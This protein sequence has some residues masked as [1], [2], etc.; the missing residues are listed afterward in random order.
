MKYK[1][2]N[3]S[4]ILSSFLMF[5]TLTCV[6][7]V[8][9]DIAD[10]NS[11][12]VVDG[13]ITNQPGPYEV[14][15]SLSSPLRNTTFETIED[16]AV[17]IEEENGP[18][19]SLKYNNTG[20]YWTDSV[21]LQGQVGNR[22]RLHITLATGQQYQSEWELLK[23]APPIDELYFRFEEQPSPRGGNEKGTR[24]Y[25]STEDPAGDT[26]FYRWEWDATWLHIAPFSSA[27]DFVGND[28]TEFREPQQVC[29]NSTESA[30]ILLESSLNN[31][32]DEIA[33]FPIHFVSTYGIE[34][35]FRY[36]ILVTQYALTEKE[37]L[38]WNSLE[39]ANENS[40]SFYDTQPQ[41][42][43]GN[44]IRLDDPSEPVL[45]Y[46]SASG[47]SQ[48]RLFINRDELPKDQVVGIAYLNDCITR[49]D[50]I[51]KERETE[52]DVFNAI[53]A[54]RRFYD[55]YRDLELGILGWILVPPECH[56][57]T[58]LGGTQ[59]KPEFWDE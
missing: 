1:A 38:F 45:G 41:S 28:R 2:T 13:L 58:E 37:F 56:D 26:K 18:L 52:Q 53:R 21:A 10:V 23:P 14:R 29:Y 12:L 43:T 30:T 8:D 20:R 16:A 51:L 42:T 59:V 35:I 6:D 44:I 47:I 7:P 5:L 33:D 19:V 50:T 31:T 17:T 3:L 25:L 11:F 22:Y 36:S 49:A 4:Y 9:L 15:L 46:F 24:I 32:R 54:G 57:C 39:E 34:L 48:K 40:G 27:V 55:F